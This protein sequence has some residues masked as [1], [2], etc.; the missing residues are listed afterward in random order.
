MSEHKHTEFLRH[1]LLYDD[2]SER[3]HME[4]NFTRLQ[5]DLLSVQRAVW[6]MAILAALALA[7][8]IYPAILLENFPYN[9]GRFIFHLLFALFVGSLICLATFMGLRMFYRRQLARQREQCHQLLTRLLASR[10]G[11]TSGN[12]KTTTA[13]EPPRAP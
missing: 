6:L 5:R 8:M 10:L 2:S 1:C 3:H 9:T 7:G 4:K 13:V 12:P 11:A